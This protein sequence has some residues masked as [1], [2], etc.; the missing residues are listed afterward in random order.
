MESRVLR[1]EASGNC[2]WI[3]ISNSLKSAE[4]F[5]EFKSNNKHESVID[6][7]RFYCK[8]EIKYRRFIFYNRKRFRFIDHSD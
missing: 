5:D 7:R 3:E 1:D 6:V 2:K 4:T 8:F